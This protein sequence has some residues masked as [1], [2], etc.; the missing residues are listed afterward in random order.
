MKKKTQIEQAIQYLSSAGYLITELRGDSYGYYEPGGIEHIDIHKA[1][2]I[3]LFRSLRIADT[4]GCR[5][6]KNSNQISYHGFRIDTYC[7]TEKDCSTVLLEVQSI[8]KLID[9]IFP[10]L[11]GLPT[12]GRYTHTSHRGGENI[13]YLIIQL[14]NQ[15]TIL[16]G[17]DGKTQ[18]NPPEVY[19]NERIELDGQVSLARIRKLIALS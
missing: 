15:E 16:Y 10:L 11:E 2:L 5:L 9:Q 4:L 7:Y 6:Y 14:D 3:T 12:D 13:Y 17:S 8:I 19:S 18:Y 1:G